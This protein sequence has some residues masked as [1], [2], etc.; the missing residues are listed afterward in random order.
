MKIRA[1]ILEAAVREGMRQ[2][3]DD[4]LGKVAA[5]LT[6]VAEVARVLG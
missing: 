4:G 3:R 6:S 2:L 5:G 1:A